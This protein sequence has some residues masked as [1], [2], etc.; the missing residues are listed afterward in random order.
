[1]QSIAIIGPILLLLAIALAILVPYLVGRVLPDHH[2]EGNLRS[3]TAINSTVAAPFMLV[4]GFMVVVLWGQINDAQKAI[5]QEADALRDIAALVGRLDPSMSAPV[6]AEL[7]AYAKAAAA[8]WP[9]LGDGNASPDA[10][11]AFNALR[12]AVLA[13]PEQSAGAGDTVLI[14]HAV[15]QMLVAQVHRSDRISAANQDIQG[16]LWLALLVGT[17]L[18]IAYIALTD[19]GPLRSRI[20]MMFLAVSVVGL[21]LLLIALL[22]NPYRGDVQADPVPFV[23]LVDEL[24][25]VQR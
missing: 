4:L 21:I 25:A 2:R 15:D 23:E 6:Q 12:D 14:D 17:I 24:E 1:V 22:D 19:T 8:E 9:S 11:R 5:Q 18:Y 3:S 10:V 20:V 7:L 13:L 16:V